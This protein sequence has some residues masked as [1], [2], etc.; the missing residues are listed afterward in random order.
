LFSIRIRNTF[1]HGAISA[2]RLRHSH[3]T[4]VD[5]VPPSLY[6]LPLRKNATMAA[7]STTQHSSEIAGRSQERPAV[8]LRRMAAIDRKGTDRN[9]AHKASTLTFIGAG[10]SFRWT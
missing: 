2:T 8:V 5:E 3:V 4:S 9:I 6:H 10:H 1:S 7:T